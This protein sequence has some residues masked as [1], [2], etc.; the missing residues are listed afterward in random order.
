MFHGIVQ[1][2][3]VGDVHERFPAAEDRWFRQVGQGRLPLEKPTEG[4]LDEFRDR[5]P[6]SGGL[7]LETFVNGIGDDQRRLHMEN[8][9]LSTATC[10][11]GWILV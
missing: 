3:P 4:G 10:Q 5:R 8:H 9:V 7:C 11:Q 6:V 1:C 2:L